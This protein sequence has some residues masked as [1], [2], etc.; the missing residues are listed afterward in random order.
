M[1][2]SGIAIVAR[3]C[4][5]CSVCKFI[6][7]V[8]YMTDLWPIQWVRI[9]FVCKRHCFLIS[10]LQSYC[11]Q[12]V[13]CLRLC[14]TSACRLWMCIR[15]TSAGVC[16]FALQTWYL[17]VGGRHIWI[18][19][20]I[21]RIGILASFN[22]WFSENLP[23]EETKWRITNYGY[24]GA[25]KYNRWTM[26]WTRCKYWCWYYIFGVK[27]LEFIQCLT[28]RFLSLSLDNFDY[29][30]FVCGFCHPNSIFV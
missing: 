23:F 27:M 10:S 12:R 6:L 9:V 8:E 11:H 2:T 29:S 19:W 3:R 25:F 18:G 7:R 28:A 21:R 1:R 24:G 30:K 20:H 15:S 17:E 22:L 26:L 4:I 14:V 13:S 16:Y 5:V